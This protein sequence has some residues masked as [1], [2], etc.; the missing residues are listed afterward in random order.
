NVAAV[1]QGGVG[2]VAGTLLPVEAI[3]QFSVQSGG[4]AEMGRNAGSSINLVIKSG[5]NN[6]HG[7]GF[8]F[9]R[10]EHL[11]ALSPLQPPGSAK[12]EIRNNQF[13]G[14]LGGP[15]V[16]NKTFYFSAFEAQKLTGAN[17]LADTAP[18]PA[19]IARATQLMNQFGV[20]VNSASTK[21]LALWPA[22]SRTGPATALN[23]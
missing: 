18:S 5:T 2:G 12:L 6:V 21:L 1:N 10:N 3:D 11:S 13:G 9:N 8:Y 4:S 20:P 23:F 14:S 16:H 17:T 19:W 7:S 15:I 22:D